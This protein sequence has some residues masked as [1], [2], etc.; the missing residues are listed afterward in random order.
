MPRVSPGRRA[1]AVSK[2]EKRES[3]TAKGARQERVQLSGTGAEGRRVAHG[4]GSNSPGPG[5]H[6]GGRRAESDRTARGAGT[7][8]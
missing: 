7:K 5:G 3:E 2:G 6:W 4:W 8:W 1:S